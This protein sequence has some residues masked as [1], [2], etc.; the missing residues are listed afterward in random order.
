MHCH[1]AFILIPLNSL[2]PVSESIPC[3]V[4]VILFSVS[5]R[6]SSR[7]P[8]ELYILPRFLFL[9]TS[10]RAVL[11]RVILL[12][13]S[14][15]IFTICVLPNWDNTSAV[16]LGVWQQCSRCR[17]CPVSHKSYCLIPSMTCLKSNEIIWWFPLWFYF[18]ELPPVHV[19]DNREI[20]CRI[21]LSI[22]TV[23][24]TYEHSGITH[25]TPFGKYGKHSTGPSAYGP[26]VRTYS[27]LFCCKSV[28]PVCSYRAQSNEI[29]MYRRVSR[30]SIPRVRWYGLLYLRT[31][32][33]DHWL[34]INRAD[35]E[36]HG[37]GNCN[38]V[39]PYYWG[40]IKFLQII[41]LPVNMLYIVKRYLSFVTANDG[42]DVVHLS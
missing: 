22:S 12:F 27:K 41:K 30:G 11:F 16:V 38:W 42:D 29:C 10:S 40:D 21:R 32:E 34:A 36:L 6:C 1:I 23:I 18:E 15:P 39:C 4:A 3:M 5:L 17:N 8:F 37:K 24:H 31:V 25:V 26:W 28:L 13:N 2:S 19:K 9:C 33:Y 35:H 20:T 7:L 14:G